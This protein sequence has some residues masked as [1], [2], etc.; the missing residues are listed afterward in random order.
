VVAALSQSIRR[1]QFNP[2]HNDLVSQIKQKSA[3]LIDLCQENRRGA[4][5]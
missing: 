1:S 3:E 2:S 5:R 4:G